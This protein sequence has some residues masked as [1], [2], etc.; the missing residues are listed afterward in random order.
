MNR[1]IIITAI[2]LAL[3]LGTE[4]YIAHQNQAEYVLKNQ[5]RKLPNFATIKADAIREFRVE[6]GDTA[7]TY[8]WQN[9]NW[10]YPAYQNVF[11][12]NDRIGSFLKDTFDNFGTIIAVENHSKFEFSQTPL[13]IHLVDSTKT[14]QETVQIGASLP[15][16]DTREAYMKVP[17]SDTIYQIHADPIR[18]LLWERLPNRPPFVDPKVLPSA[19]TRR[20]IKRV[21]FN[22]AQTPVTE[23]ERIEIEKDEAQTSPQDGPQYE[24][25]A[26]INNKR[27]KVV[28]ASAYAYL[29]FLSRLKYDTLEDPTQK[30]PATQSI[31]LIDDQDIADTLEIGNWNSS[32]TP[33]YHKTSGHLYTVANNKAKLLF[34]TPTLLDTLPRTTP[35]HQAEPTGAFSLASP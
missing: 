25:F 7:W 35:Y 4:Q 29:G 11:G 26:H 21:I 22:N 14:W 16:T 34:L 13:T 2:L 10:H 33:V 24:W 23:I 3:F 19:L 8:R 15:G 9:G 6:R 17:Q 5:L 28:N 20:A 31:I 30:R 12:L 32:Q 27:Q 1:L 18:S